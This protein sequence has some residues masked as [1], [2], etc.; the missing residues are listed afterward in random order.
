MRNITRAKFRVKIKSLAEESRIIRREIRR[1]RGEDNSFVQGQL[2]GHRDCVVRIESRATQWAYA[3]LRGVPYKAIESKA[4]MR[5]DQQRLLE[6]RAA[7][8]VYSLGSQPNHFQ[9]ICDWVEGKAT[10]QEAA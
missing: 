1:Y 3:Y 8:I 9:G 6:I 4:N 10:S 7:K 2:Q 5:K